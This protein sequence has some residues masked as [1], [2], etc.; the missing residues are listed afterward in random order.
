MFPLLHSIRER[1]N[2]RLAELQILVGGDTTEVLCSDQSLGLQPLVR[3]VDHE[4]S[5][6][7]SLSAKFLLHK[8]KTPSKAELVFFMI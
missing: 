2:G 8:M 7:L 1:P 4:G 5:V 3:R 6:S